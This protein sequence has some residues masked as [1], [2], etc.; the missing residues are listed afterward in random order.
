MG[1]SA[2]S[3]AGD[4]VNPLG[5]GIQKIGDTFGAGS[6]FDKVVNPFGAAASTATNALFPGGTSNNQALP[7]STGQA[8]TTNTNGITFSNQGLPSSYPSSALP[9]A[10][11]NIN[12]LYGGLASAAPQAYGQAQQATNEATHQ[13]IGNIN[14]IYSGGLNTQQ[15]LSNNAQGQ[16][17]GI[18]NQ[19]LAQLNELLNN[20]DQNFVSQLGPQGQ[21][22]S[23]IM[24]E[25]NNYGLTPNSGAFQSAL[26]NQLGSLGAQNQLSLGSALVNNGAN[27]QQNLLS[28]GLGGQL[29][30]AQQG[31]NQAGAASNLG[32]TQNLTL[33]SEGAL[34]PLGYQQQAA[35]TQSGIIN[36]AAQLPIDYWG[37]Q[38][39][40]A[41][42]QQLANQNAAT[43]Q[44]TSSNQLLGNVLG[45]GAGALA[46]AK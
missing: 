29:S 46:A 12:S 35:N 24:G 33:G 22:G 34:A 17:Q 2:G 11:N 9:E 38:N 16:S 36:Q 20:Y 44:S 43:Q 13:G 4:I 23:Q 27:S 15:Q 28:Q 41:F 30:T 10:Y 37:S 14:S 39:N 31:T 45:S 19:N 42:A 7:G 8:G 25:F 18:T 32:T 6:T 5:A 21:L 1:G 40:Q 26:G 3:I